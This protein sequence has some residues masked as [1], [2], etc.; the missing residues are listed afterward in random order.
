[1]AK[2]MGGL[3]YALSANIYFDT[4]GGAAAAINQTDIFLCLGD[5]TQRRAERVSFEKLDGDPTVSRGTYR[6][7]HTYGATG[8]YVVTARLGEF[9]VG[10][11]NV[12][13]PGLSRFLAAQTILNTTLPNSTA[14]APTPIFAG[15][16]R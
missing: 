15:G 14:P 4:E 1:M 13:N 3:T 16:L 11:V 8:T 12:P 9:T 2:N 5:G 10:I 7:T 6:V